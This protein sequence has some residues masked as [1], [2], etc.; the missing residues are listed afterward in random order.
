MPT[1]RA[2]RLGSGVVLW[3]YV[4]SHLLNHA[5]GL[6]SLNAAEQGL[7]VAL[8]VWH[9]ALGTLL[10][11]SAFAVHLVLAM[12]GLYQRPT[13]R[14]PA[15]ELLRIGAGLA[16]PMLLVGHAVATR[17]AYEWYG[18]VPLYQRVVT[19]LLH[20]GSE[21][22]QLALLAPGWLHGCMGLHMALRK[23][24]LY[25]RWRWVWAVAAL[26]L[27]CLAGAGFLQMAQEVATLSGFV[28]T[29]A[30][31]ARTASLQ[32]LRV[33]ILSAYGL[34]LAMV[35]VARGIRAVRKPRY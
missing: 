7:R 12:L 5:L 33:Q 19:A 35:V 10:L 13:L 30:K 25:Q 22:R 2:L 26:L 32:D 14:L 11:Y 31:A 8:W 15:V 27:P 21:G 24:A 3:V 4:A 1:S 18:V 20:T 17:M 6:V 9:S 34:L 28:D 29:G 16:I 23:R